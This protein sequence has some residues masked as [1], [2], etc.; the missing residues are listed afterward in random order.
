[1]D[2]V[3]LAEDICR[4]AR[5]LFDRGY[6]HG[7]TGNLSARTAGGFLVTPTGSSFGSLSPDRLSR[8]DASGAHLGGDRPTKELPLHLAFYRTRGAACG[9]VVH[10]HSHHATAWSCLPAADPANVLPPLTPYPEMMFGPV[11][12][13]PYLPPG[14]TNL[15]AAI[16]A[17]DGR[18]AAV[19]MANHG[20]V[21]TA[22]SLAAAVAGAEELEAAARLALT[23]A[24][25]PAQAIP[26]DQIAALSKWRR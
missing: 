12:L 9:A 15:G 1:V 8:L 3:A 17:L 23:L 2:D 4:R 20:P 5:S 19:L 22:A 10:L 21:V 6:V 14:S 11:A 13:I 16:E 25:R 18:H 7:S 26:P 24:G